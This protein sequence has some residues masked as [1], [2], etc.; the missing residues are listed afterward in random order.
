MRRQAIRS[1]PARNH[2]TVDAT[3]PQPY[4]AR[5]LERLKQRLRP[6][7]DPGRPPAPQAPEGAVEDMAEGDAYQAKLLEEIE[8]HK[9]YVDVN[10]LP[11]IFGY[12]SNR[13]LVPMLQE[14]GV[15][16]PNEF[17]ADALIASARRCQA[18]NPCFVS[19]G[20]GNCDT[21]VAVA[22]LLKE[23]GLQ[24]FRIECVDITPDMLE[25]GRK[26]AAD[27]GLTDVVVPTAGDFNSWQP[28]RIY[29]GIFANQSLHHVVNLEGLFDAMY[30]ALDTQGS[31]VVNDMIGRNGH[32][33]WPEALAPLQEFWKE[34]PS[35]YRYNQQLKRMEDEFDDWDCSQYGFEGIR[36][37]DVLPLLAERFQFEIFIGFSNVVDV[38]IDRNFGH[39]FDAEGEWDQD[40]IDRVHA[41]DEAGLAN[42]TL[43][44]THM[45]AVLRK[46]RVAEPFFSR[47]LSPLRAIRDP[48]APS[49]RGSTSRTA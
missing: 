36:S 29:Q 14:V 13:Y 32:M 44:P 6:H 35:S 8:F 22:K 26:L 12:W 40:F 27:E 37:Q 46:E 45:L 25:R 34:L 9:D 3:R 11:E 48:A 23:R 5:M 21:E 31:L 15:T 30:S 18:S 49:G 24:S 20:S 43:T 19:I 16:N 41:F 33:R 38:F 1:P 47:G 17:A 10:A 7:R 39:N 4:T 28:S 42:G 2:A